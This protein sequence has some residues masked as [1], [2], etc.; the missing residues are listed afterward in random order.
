M[1]V[2]LCLSDCLSHPSLSTPIKRSI[3]STSPGFA[4]L[5][6]CLSVSLIPP[7]SI[8]PSNDLSIAPHQV[9][10]HSLSVCLSPIKRSIYSTSPGCASL[11]VCL[12]VSLIPPPSIHPS[13]DLSIAPHQVAR[14]SLSVCL[15]YPPSLNT[16]IKRSIYCTSPGCASLSVCLSLLSPLPQYTHQTIHLLHLTR[17]RVTLCLSVSLIP[18]PSVHPSNDLSIAP[19]QV[20]RHSLSVCLSH[21]PLSTPIKRSIYSTSP[22]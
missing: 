15:S 1:S 6:V 9:E 12:S 17:L 18:P 19:H 13:N 2:T 14:H 3:Y 7:P 22:G 5:S 20:E 16:P 4:S 8:H 21:P 10:R 11:S